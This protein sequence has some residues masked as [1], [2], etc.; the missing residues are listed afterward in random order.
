MNYGEK[1]SEY[2]RKRIA[3]INSWPNVEPFDA[4]K[5]YQKRCSDYS[6]KYGSVPFLPMKMWDNDDITYNI[7]VSKLIDSLEMMPLWPNRA[8]AFLFGGFDYYSGVII[9]NGNMTIRLKRI[10]TEII[11]LTKVNCDVW[12]IIKLLFDEIPMSVSAYIYKRE[13]TDT[14]VYNRV[15]NDECDKPTHRKQL[16][17]SI[18]AKYGFDAN[19]PGTIRKANALIRRLFRNDTIDVDG[20]SFNISNEDRLQILLSGLLYTL[21]NDT[22]HGLSISMTKSSQT[23]ARRYALNYYSFLALYTISMIFVIRNDMTINEN[24]K[25]VLLKQSISDNISNMKALFGNQLTK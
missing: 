15:A 18:N 10:A 17:L 21:R 3:Y 13:F 1:M 8:F 9:R 22:L 2:S 24:E 6:D 23:S 12:E 25:Y 16:L 19:S 5:E 11:E 4:E 20:N 14:K 7:F